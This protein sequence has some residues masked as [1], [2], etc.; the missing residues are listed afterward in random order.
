MFLPK[1]KVHEERTAEIIDRKCLS[2]QKQ[3]N[4]IQGSGNAWQFRNAG[5][6][7]VGIHTMICFAP[8]IQKEE[9]ELGE[10]DTSVG[11]ENLFRKMKL[12]DRFQPGKETLRR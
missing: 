9:G 2:V 7:L 3:K 6:L 5:L 12:T 11:K 10:R 8:T 1:S 4:W